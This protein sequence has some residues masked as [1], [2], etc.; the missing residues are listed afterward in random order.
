MTR[1]KASKEVLIPIKWDT[2]LRLRLFREKGKA[3]TGF[4]S[5]LEYLD[6]RWKPVVRYDTAHGFF[7][8]DFYSPSGKQKRKEKINIQDLKAAVLV[9]D[10][11]LR[12]NYEDYIEKYKRDEL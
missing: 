9:A 10:K 8:R 11:D 3:L 12:K 7:H 4:T 1:K 6:D 2:R 5:Q